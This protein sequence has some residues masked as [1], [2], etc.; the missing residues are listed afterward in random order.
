MTI[1]VFSD[2]PVVTRKHIC[3]NCGYE[4]EFNNVDL[5][6]HRSDSDG[7]PCEA[8]GKYLVCPRKECHFR[9]LVEPK[10]GIGW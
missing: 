5:E 10:N 2:K 1:K 6:L 9:N 3:K 8:R 7:D 4:L